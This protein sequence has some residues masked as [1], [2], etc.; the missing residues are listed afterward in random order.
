MLTE[1]ILRISL[2]RGLT[3]TTYSI[4]VYVTAYV[5]KLQGKFNSIVSC[6]ATGIE[7]ECY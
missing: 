1:Y 3:V 4:E 7:V 6:I 2:E 5:P